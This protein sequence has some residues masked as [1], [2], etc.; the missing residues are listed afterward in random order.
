MPL[1]MK[2]ADWIDRLEVINKRLILI[3]RTSDKL[4][5]CETIRKVITPNI[6]KVWE[7]DYLLKDG[8]NDKAKNLKAVKSIL[9]RSRKRTGMTRWNK[10]H[11]ATR[12]NSKY[13]NFNE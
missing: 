13:R 11:P 2:V 10:N 9:R 5:E 4:T 7:R 6:P 12:N 1:N 8:N 3:D